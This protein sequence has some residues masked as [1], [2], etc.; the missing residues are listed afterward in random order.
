MQGYDLSNCGKLLLR[1]HQGRNGYYYY[2]HCL[3]SC[4]VRFK[5]EDTNTLFLRELSK[6]VP[7]PGMLEAYKRVIDGGYRLRTK[8]Q[9]EDIKLIT[10]KINQANDDIA[11][12]RQKTVCQDEMDSGLQDH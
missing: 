8:T 5:A 3:A 7:K 12:G 9:R 10:D 6:F 1:A 2:Y 11:R 4:G